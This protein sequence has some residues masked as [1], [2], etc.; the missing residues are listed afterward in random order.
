MKALLV[1]PA[2][3]AL[4]I[5][6]IAQAPGRNPGRPE[7]ITIAMTDGGFL[8]GRFALRGGTPYVLRLTNRSGKGHNLTQKA[9]FQDARVDPHDRGWVRDGRISLRPGERAT[10]HFLAPDVRPGATYQFSSTV[11]GDAASDYKGVFLIR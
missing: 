11:L 4:A 2:A 8:P 1:A 3:L 9:F 7:P 6:A 10:V 5:P